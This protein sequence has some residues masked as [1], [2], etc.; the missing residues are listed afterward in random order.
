[1]EESHRALSRIIE[2]EDNDWEPVLSILIP[3]YSGKP[4]PLLR[5]GNAL[6]LPS[7]FSPLSFAGSTYS[8]SDGEYWNVPSL[9]RDFYRIELYDT[10]I[11]DKTSNKHMCTVTVSTDN[12]TY[13]KYSVNGKA[14]QSQETELPVEVTVRAETDTFL[15]VSVSELPFNSSC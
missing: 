15:P 5:L 3:P 9:V 10:T 11:E 2:E 14:Y 8:L 7:L 4:M 1:M 12:C 13:L 6:S